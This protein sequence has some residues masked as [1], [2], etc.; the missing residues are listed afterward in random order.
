MMDRLEQERKKDPENHQLYYRCNQLILAIAQVGGQKDLERLIQVWEGYPEDSWHRG[1]A[2]IPLSDLWIKLELE[3]LSK[4]H[5]PIKVDVDQKPPVLPPVLQNAAPDL[6]RAW[7]AYQSVVKLRPSIPLAGGVRQEPWMRVQETWPKFYRVLGDLLR[8][9]SA[10]PVA[11]VTMFEWGGWCGTGSESL[12]E[13]KNRALFMAFLR[14]KRYAEALSQVFSTFAERSNLS[15]YPSLTENQWQRRYIEMCGQDWETLCAGAAVDPAYNSPKALHHLA[16]HGSDASARLL[17]LM[18]TFP[19]L[20]TSRDYLIAVA[21][22]ITPAH[23]PPPQ[24]DGLIILRADG[25]FELQRLAEP[26]IAA[27]NCNCSEFF[28]TPFNH[29]S[30]LK[31]PKP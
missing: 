3:I 11:Q 9:K 4:Q 23:L 21:L 19:Q 18:H 8:G 5:L 25:M 7:L 14:E 1:R 29:R 22:M 10:T 2:F 12:Y 24:R 15:L 20:N 17:A 13:P 31:R 30:R 28:T 6:Q 16:S 26:R 27:I